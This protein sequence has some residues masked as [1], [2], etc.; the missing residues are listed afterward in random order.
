MKTEKPSYPLLGINWREPGPLFPMAAEYMG[1]VDVEFS[2]LAVR[3]VAVPGNRI[4]RQFG[5][6]RSAARKVQEIEMS[7]FENHQHLRDQIAQIHTI[8][9]IPFSR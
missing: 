7:M 2:L 4:A 8:G 6:I 5:D 1:A 3:N 9:A